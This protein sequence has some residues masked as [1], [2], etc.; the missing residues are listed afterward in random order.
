MTI[1]FGCPKC[2][3]VMRAPDEK[4][5]VRVKCQKCGLAMEVP[6][7][8]GK[9]I[10]VR[11]TTGSNP[12]SKPAAPAQPPAPDY[13]PGPSRADRLLEEAEA[14]KVKNDLRAR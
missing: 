11:P 1:V 3:H 2:N 8:K 6:Y 7:P 9:L 13:V 12:G 14:L 4:G 10:E 5:G